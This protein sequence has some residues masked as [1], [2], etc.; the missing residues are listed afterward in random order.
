MDLDFID[1]EGVEQRSISY[2]FL[3]LPSDLLVVDAL[4]GVFIK[5]V[6][7]GPHSSFAIAGI[8]FCTISEFSS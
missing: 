4:S 8:P 2:L 5:D 1:Y 6:A 7:C 3:P